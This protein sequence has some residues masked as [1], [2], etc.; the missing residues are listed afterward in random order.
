VACQDNPQKTAKA[1]SHLRDLPWTRHIWP[2]RQKICRPTPKA[3]KNLPLDPKSGKFS[4]KSGRYLPR[5]RSL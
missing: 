3:A 2:K 5:P 1:A 4:A